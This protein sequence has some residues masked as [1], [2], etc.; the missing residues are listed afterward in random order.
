MVRLHDRSQGVFYDYPDLI[1]VVSRISHFDDVEAGRA[2]GSHLHPTFIL[3]PPTHDRSYSVSVP[4]P[5][6]TNDI[7]GDSEMH[8]LDTM[9]D[10]M[11]LII[12]DYSAN[13]YTLVRQE[14]LDPV[15][16]DKVVRNRCLTDV[17]YSPIVN[18][19]SN[20]TGS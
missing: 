19:F 2:W 20:K 18:P 13:G 3:R 1:T 12:Q 8:L 5:V 17:M 14:Q 4:D 11:E 7:S 6:Q 9:K 16:N 10:L 15:G